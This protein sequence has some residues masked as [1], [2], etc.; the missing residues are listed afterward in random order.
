M[1]YDSAG[2]DEAVEKKR[3]PFG[4]DGRGVSANEVRD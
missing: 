1:D 4:N 3:V 2:G